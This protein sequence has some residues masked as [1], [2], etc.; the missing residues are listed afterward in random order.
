M[1]NGRLN[2]LASLAETYVTTPVVPLHALGHA[3]HEANP[4]VGPQA[5]H[6]DP[7]VDAA[8]L[9]A[10]G[11]LDKAL[12]LAQRDIAI[13]YNRLRPHGAANPTHE[14]LHMLLG[15][16][17]QMHGLLKELQATVRNDMNQGTPGHAHG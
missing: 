15:V 4:N 16:M 12:S 5:A 14:E 3:A 7:A 2:S 6:A 17:Q 8:I 10:T 11:D 9:K 13:I 1:Q